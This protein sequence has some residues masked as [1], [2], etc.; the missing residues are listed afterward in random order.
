[1]G[2]GEGVD[3]CEGTIKRRKLPRRPTSS[4]L[5]ERRHGRH[6]H[7]KQDDHHDGRDEVPGLVFRP[8]RRVVVVMTESTVTIVV[9]EVVSV[10]RRRHDD[11]GMQDNG[12]RI[13]GW[14]C[15]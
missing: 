5:N 13:V 15:Q 14:W 8:G 7:D 4:I 11:K 12:R 10:G 9:D 3:E 1:M 6:T 2:G